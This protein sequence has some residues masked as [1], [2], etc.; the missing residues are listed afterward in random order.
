MNVFLL[1]LFFIQTIFPY[2]ASLDNYAYE[3]VKYK[4]AAAL[5]VETKLEKPLL[6]LST[7]VICQPQTYNGLSAKDYAYYSNQDRQTY[8]AW[9][10]QNLFLLNNGDLSARAK[11]F[12]ALVY[13]D[14]SGEYAEIAPALLKVLQARCD[15]S[16]KLITLDRDPY[17]TACIYQA[18]KEALPH[19]V[20]LDVLRSMDDAASIELLEAEQSYTFLG[21]YWSKFWETLNRLL[22]DYTKRSSCSWHQILNNPYNLKIK[23]LFYKIDRKEFFEAQAIAQQD[24][25]YN[26]IFTACCSGFIQ[27][28]KQV[29]ARA[30]ETTEKLEQKKDDCP[31]SLGKAFYEIERSQALRES[32]IQPS[33]AHKTFSLSKNSEKLLDAVG[34]NGYHFKECYGNQVQHVLHQEH[35]KI[36]ED[37]ANIYFVSH[38]Q[39]PI[40]NIIKDTIHFVTRARDYNHA[41][42]VHKAMSVTDC[43]WAFLSCAQSI[44]Q[45][46]GEGVYQGT[47]NFVDYAIDHPIELL[48]RPLIG[49]FILAYHLGTLTADLIN[50][51]RIGVNAWQGN[52][53]AQQEWEQIC[54]NITAIKDALAEKGKTLS[55]QEGVK[56]ATALVTE[57]L[58][59]YKCANLL[60][61]FYQT[62]ECKTL[63][64]I[65]NY[66]NTI[67]PPLHA[68]AL[69]QEGFEIGIASQAA[70][71]ATGN[72]NSVL[73]KLEEFGGGNSLFASME[74]IGSG[75][76]DFIDED[77][78]VKVKN[79]NEFFDLKFGN[80]LKSK[81]EKVKGQ[82]VYRIAKKINHE[83]LEKGDFF[84]LDRMHCDHLEI[85]TAKG[86]IKGVLNLDGTI[87]FKKT[88][89][90]IAQNR[91]IKI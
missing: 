55:L 66:K 69:T 71:I 73:K 34:V 49:N 28:Q 17:L 60:S 67:P 4:Q 45:G 20:Y 56:H 8:Y 5:P 65:D 77:R 37:S 50:V 11:A 13:G 62:G 39:Q 82:Q 15:D 76:S 12:K 90:A 38:Q 80:F 22:N 88:N 61:K 84:Y 91:K 75:K 46:V 87:N 23:E 27:E 58:L 9:L 24:Q 51:G 1:F 19:R 85:F 83:Y 35:I 81:A 79:M 44:A 47:K 72:T 86:K 48:T 2:A 32:L 31:F 70:L 25:L 74:K 43:C 18:L 52:K 14:K 21:Y 7:A 57:T 42:F 33:F 89:I 78:I 6:K 29:R 26:Q 59:D 63:E 36:L 16:G 40:K 68:V 64:L 3:V 30:T 41:G 10:V 53:N 54:T